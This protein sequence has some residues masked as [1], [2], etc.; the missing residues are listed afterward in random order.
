MVSHIIVNFRHRFQHMNGIYEYLIY[1]FVFSGTRRIHECHTHKRTTTNN[2]GRKIFTCLIGIKLIDGLIAFSKSKW[3]ELWTSFVII[4]ECELEGTF[5][6]ES[7]DCGDGGDPPLILLR[8]RTIAWMSNPDE[9]V[10]VTEVGCSLEWWS[11]LVPFDLWWWWWLLL[12]LLVVNRNG[13]LLS[14]L[15]AIEISTWGV[16]KCICEK[17]CK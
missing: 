13:P 3:R 16:R 2:D 7:A 11:L 15:S 6:L 10:A 17:N 12:L 4:D 14:L 9:V 8:G 1:L 5:E